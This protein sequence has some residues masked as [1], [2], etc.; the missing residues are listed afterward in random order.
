MFWT[1]RLFFAVMLVCLALPSV[2]RAAESDYHHVH[3]MAPDAKAAAAWYMEHMGCEAYEREGACRYD[4]VQVLFI[5]REPEG[6]SVGTAVDHVGFSFED[7]DAKM[8]E[9]KAAGLTV[10]EDVREID[11]LFKLAFLEDP[12]GTKIEA[13]E[14]HEDLG[15]HHLHLRSNDPDAT[16]A[17]YHN[18]F[19]GERDAMKGR[20]EGLRW[21][22]IWLLVSEHQGEALVPMQTRSFHH[23]GWSVADLDAFGSEIAAKGIEFSGEPRAI[24]NSAGQ[25]LIISFVTGPDNAFIEVLEVVE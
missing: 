22:R 8:A 14:D 24:T 5:E 7:L 4:H 12:W 10:L 9:W 19:G 15:L 17:W 16:L 6:G 20:L 23:L 3:L 1:R 2:A 18:V 13:V 25:N 11:G 21:G